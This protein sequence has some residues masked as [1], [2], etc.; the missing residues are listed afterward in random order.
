MDESSGGTCGAL[1]VI[2]LGKSPADDRRALPVASSG[3]SADGDCRALPGL[4]EGEDIGDASPLLR[5]EREEGTANN[6]LLPE[7]KESLLL[8]TEANDVSMVLF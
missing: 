4:S 5:K 7:D 2:S 1:P 3:K 6:E 8:S